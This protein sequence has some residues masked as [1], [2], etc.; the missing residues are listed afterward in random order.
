MELIHL[1]FGE[2]FLR[3]IIFERKVLD[4]IL[5]ILNLSCK[6][7]SLHSMVVFSS[8]VKVYKSML[9]SSERSIPQTG[10]SIVSHIARLTG[11]GLTEAISIIYVSIISN[12]KMVFY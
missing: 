1:V 7:Q 9:S 12:I 6:T 3:E 4:Y 2:R 5:T 11:G 10:Q 8:T